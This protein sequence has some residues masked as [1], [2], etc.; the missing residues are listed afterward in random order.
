MPPFSRVSFQV[1]TPGGGFLNAASGAGAPRREERRS[2]AAAIGFSTL[3]ATSAREEV[4]PKDGGFMAYPSGKHTKNYGKSP[5][6][7]WENSLFRL[8]HFQ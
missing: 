3:N 1:R 8:G 4:A 7:L 2:G 6:F 5:C